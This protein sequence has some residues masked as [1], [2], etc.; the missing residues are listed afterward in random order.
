MRGVVIVGRNCSCKF[1]SAVQNPAL[2][3]TR[4]RDGKGWPSTAQSSH[5]HPGEFRL[6]LGALCLP[7][8]SQFGPILVFQFPDR[9][10]KVI[11]APCHHLRGPS[12][13]RPGEGK[14]FGHRNEDQ[15]A[16][17]RGST[18]VLH[19]HQIAG[20]RVVV[21]SKLHIRSRR[22]RGILESFAACIAHDRNEVL[23][24]IA[25]PSWPRVHRR[26]VLSPHGLKLLK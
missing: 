7:P 26:K 11:R 19:Q 21:I 20:A 23:G 10:S 15:I 4:A 6:Q 5:L 25:Q 12:E 18:K 8:G 9:P 17:T 14:Y 22:R 24:T 2:C 3:G 1:V 16:A 13:R